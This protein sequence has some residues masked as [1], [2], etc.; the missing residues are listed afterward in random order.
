MHQLKHEIT[1]WTL[2]LAGAADI[3]AFGPDVGS[4]ARALPWGICED[5]IEPFLIITLENPATMQQA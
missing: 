1:T 5:V 2:R 3:R 4:W